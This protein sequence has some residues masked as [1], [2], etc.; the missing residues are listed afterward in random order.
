MKYSLRSLIAVAV[1][2]PPLLGLWVSDE[3]LLSVLCQLT[4]WAFFLMIALACLRFAVNSPLLR[5]P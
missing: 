4:F 2:V 3:G 1:V 5:R